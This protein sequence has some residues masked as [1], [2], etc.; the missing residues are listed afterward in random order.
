MIPTGDREVHTTTPRVTGDTIHDDARPVRSRRRTGI[1]VKRFD[2]SGGGGRPG[3]PH[4][5]KVSTLSDRLRVRV[6]V[7]PR[8]N[9]SVTTS[10]WSTAFA[11]VLVAALGATTAVPAAASVSLT[12]GT[13][14]VQVRNYVGMRADKATKALETASLD[15][16][17]SKLVIKKS[18]WWVTKQSPKAGST[19]DTGTVV[20]LSVSKTKPMSDAKRISTAESL[21]LAQLPEAPIWEGTTAKGIVIDTSDVCVDRTYGPTGGIDNAGGN[22][23]YVIVTFPSKKLGEPQ[24]GT[25]AD[26]APIS[27][28]ATEHVTV[29]PALA[30]DPGLM[31]STNYGSK[32]PLTVPY[33]VV[34]CEN[35][36]INSR[37]LQIVTLDD[38]N[39]VTY[40]ANGTARAH[41]DHSNLEAI[42]AANP[43]IP[44]S[45]IDIS[46]V[47]GLGLS[48]CQ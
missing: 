43:T 35:I 15:W 27:A 37:K 39:G 10:R 22:A 40:S 38:P 48:L 8:H 6:R 32:W 9:A 11:V 34:H 20:K 29:P 17:F 4:Q 23:G 24:D 21:V 3:T 16:K 41:T 18:N 47:I 12:S 28:T 31:V 26:Y 46:P 1:G 13:D 7:S 45:K 44:E 42:W 2:G 25:C 36:T 19:V 5:D 30:N 33:A 14:T